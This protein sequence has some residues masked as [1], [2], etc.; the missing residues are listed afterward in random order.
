MWGRQALDPA[1]FPLAIN[2]RE[3]VVPGEGILCHDQRRNLT[4]QQETAQWLGG[5]HVPKAILTA[6]LSSLVEIGMAVLSQAASSQT[7]ALS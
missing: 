2:E 5:L 4:D 6:L 3:F 7:T 1:G